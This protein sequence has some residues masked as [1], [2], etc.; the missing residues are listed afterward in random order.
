MYNN[1]EKYGA[2]FRV[3]TY[4]N[5]H[6]YGQYVYSLTNGKFLISQE[7]DGQDGSSNGIYV[8]IYANKRERQNGIQN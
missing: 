4:T 1:G 5:C 3:N 2:E 8:Y 6:Q 7:S